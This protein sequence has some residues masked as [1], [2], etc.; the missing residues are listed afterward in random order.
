MLLIELIQYSYKV[1][2]HNLGTNIN[3]SFIHQQIR[4]LLCEILELSYEEYVALQTTLKI[5][6]EKINDLKLSID[7][8]A[9]GK[10]LAYILNKQFFWKNNF[11]VNQHVLIPRLDSE[12]LIDSLLQ[13]V[14]NTLLIKKIFDIGIGSGNLLLSLL[15]EFSSAQGVGTDIS[16]T[17]LEVAKHNIE[18]L[19]LKSRCYLINTD[20]YKGIKGTFDI[21]ICNPPYIA[22]HDT[23]IE[24][25][26]KNFEPHLALFTNDYSGVEY[27]QKILSNIKNNMHND[28]LLAIEIGYNQYHIVKKLCTYY[29]FS[30]VYLYKDYAKH[31]RVLIIKK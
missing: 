11:Y 28:T 9:M 4:I 19:N 22:L 23:N 10:P 30:R 5:S 1:I 16:F 18:L 31:D 26:V 21:I 3:S 14:K 6:T 20:L 25:S 17:A 13:H 8:L 12:I 15:L 7:S 27:Y 2:F 29:G 24:S